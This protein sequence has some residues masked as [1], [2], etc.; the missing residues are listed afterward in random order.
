MAYSNV[1]STPL[2]NFEAGL[3]YKNIN[4]AS[5]WIEFSII[6]EEEVKLLAW[7]TT[8]WTLPTNL[9]LIVNPN[10]EYVKIKDLKNNK[11]LII[12]E[13]RIDDLFNI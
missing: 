9:A 11:I 3:N 4:E 13:C 12:A 10:F 5:I 8:P 6:D 2:S 1:C 7:T